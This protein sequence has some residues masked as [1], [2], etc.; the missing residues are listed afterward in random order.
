MNGR[1]SLLY[2]GSAIGTTGARVEYRGDGCCGEVFDMKMPGMI[3][4]ERCSHQS[5]FPSQTPRQCGGKANGRPWALDNNP[6]GAHFTR[7]ACELDTV[8]GVFA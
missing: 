3:R 1:P 4:H 2:A 7:P 8:Y 5:L 6:D